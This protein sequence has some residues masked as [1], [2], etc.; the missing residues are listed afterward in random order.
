MPCASSSADRK[1]TIAEFPLNECVLRKKTVDQFRFR[2]TPPDRGI[3]LRECVAHRRQQF[4]AFGIEIIEQ[5]AP[6][7]R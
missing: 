1:P 3:Q 7:L 2:R 4:V 5:L 6:Q